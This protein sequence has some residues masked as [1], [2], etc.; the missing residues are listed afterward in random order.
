VGYNATVVGHRLTSCTDKIHEIRATF[1]EIPAL[2]S[3]R[4]SIVDTPGFD[5]TYKND[6]V[7]LKQIADWVK[8]AYDIL[9]C[10]RTKAGQLRPPTTDTR[11]IAFLGASYIFTASTITAL[12]ERAAAI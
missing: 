10:L 3:Y 6:T 5:D 11:I 4:I 7:I 8:K 9:F 2:R 1:E 12:R